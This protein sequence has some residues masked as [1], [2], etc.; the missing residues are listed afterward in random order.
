MPEVC[1]YIEEP[2]APAVFDGTNVADGYLFGLM[3]PSNVDQWALAVDPIHI[4]EVRCSEERREL[5]K[6]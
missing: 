1:D 6:R 3:A 4:F 5:S 2:V